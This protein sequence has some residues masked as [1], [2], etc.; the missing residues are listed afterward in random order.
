MQKIED[1]ELAL[2]LREKVNEFNKSSLV[3]PVSITVAFMALP[4]I[5]R[6]FLG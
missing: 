4:E 2:K 6:E 1:K 5:A 3:L